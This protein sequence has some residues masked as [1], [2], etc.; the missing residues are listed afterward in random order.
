[1]AEEKTG[2][3]ENKKDD[4]IVLNLFSNFKCDQLTYFR[5][6]LTKFMIENSLSYKLAPKLAMLINSLTLKINFNAL[7]EVTA[8]DNHLRSF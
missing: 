4:E 2:K 8:Q 7:K 5:Y 3:E 1:M 6:E